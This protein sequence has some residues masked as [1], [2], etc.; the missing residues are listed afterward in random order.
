MFI[1]GC[2]CC[3]GT[4]TAQCPCAC[5]DDSPIPSGVTIRIDPGTPTTVSGPTLSADVIAAVKKL[6]KGQACATTTYP[7]EGEDSKCKPSWYA[8]FIADEMPDLDSSTYASG[9][10]VSWSSTLILRSYVGDYGAACTRWFAAFG[11]SS[12]G[13]DYGGSYVAI[14]NPVTPFNGIYVSFRVASAP[15]EDIITTYELCGLSTKKTLT[16]FMTGTTSFVWRFF[17]APIS[18]T[19]QA[20][21]F[22][23]SVEQDGVTTVLRFPNATMTI[24]DGCHAN[25]CACTPPCQ[26]K[27]ILNGVT[28]DC[29]P[30]EINVS[31]SLVRNEGTF[32][33]EGVSGRGAAFVGSVTTAINS[34]PA[35]TLP[36]VSW[37]GNAA[38]YRYDY[39]LYTTTYLRYEVTLYCSTVCQPAQSLTAACVKA[40][41]INK[42]T[43]TPTPDPAWPVTSFT[44]GSG[45]FSKTVSD[46]RIYYS[47]N[48]AAGDQIATPTLTINSVCTNGATTST[49]DASGA[50]DLVS[51][52]SITAGL[53]AVVGNNI[54]ITIYFDIAHLT[55]SVP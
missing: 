52:T 30:P 4:T 38:T 2:L 48:W 45:S 20:D 5:D 1:P 32:P 27:T 6:A 36:L 47:G 24:Q 41:L 18:Q 9:S 49:Y 53:F 43:A 55:V 34:L 54:P 11:Y 23:A 15:S 16:G 46:L 29:L 17:G 42:S 10:G 26:R 21:V 3:G 51:G 8:P 25:V 31:L 37:D 28:Y 7:S 12:G 35:M 14:R 40:W 22:E 44:V 33:D 39:P 19:L 50:Q 13:L